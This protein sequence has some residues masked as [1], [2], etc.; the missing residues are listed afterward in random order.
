M[1]LIL[2]SRSPRRR[3]LLRCLAIDFRA[4]TPAEED[5]PLEGRGGSYS[6]M[7]RRAARQ[8]ARSVAR[9]GPEVVL[10]ADTIVVCDG[11]VMGKPASATDARRMLCRLSGR[12]H[13][14][15]TGIALV[16]DGWNMDAYERTEVEF[17]SLS[18]AE[19]K[20]YV[21]TG[22]PMDKAGAYAIQGK[23]AALIRAVRGCYTNVIGLPLPKL[24]AMLAEFERAT[25][26]RVWG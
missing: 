26:L 16:S 13:R 8:K 20:R 6:R 23:G 3:F 9:R 2:A 1:V 25:G 7:A 24:V 22:E 18:K 17:R 19:I 4:V 21:A 12:R 10:G 14:V 5:S 11:E 15:Y